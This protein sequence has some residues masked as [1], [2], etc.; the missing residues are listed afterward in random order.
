MRKQ[1]EIN[2]MIQKLSYWITYIN[3]S[4]SKSYTDINK[5]S[6]GFVMNLL[7][8]IYDLNLEDLNKEQAN[9]PGIDLGDA[10]KGMAVQVT[11]EKKS[12]KIKDTY[13]K[14][15]SPKNNIGG[16][17]IG[18]IYNKKVYFF[19]ITDEWKYRFGQS[20]VDELALI[21]QNR[22]CAED[23]ITAGDVIEII[24][25]LFDSN[26]SKFQKVYKLISQYIDTLP[27]IINDQMIVEGFLPCFDRPMFITP[28]YL[29]CNLPD[30]EQ[31]ISDTIEA[32]NTGIYRLRDGTIIKKIIPKTELHDRNLLKE[33]DLIIKDLIL[34]RS[35]YKALIN[36]GEIKKC[37]CDNPN[38]DVHLFSQEACKVM[39]SDRRNILKRVK[40]LSPT[41]SGEFIDI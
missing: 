1:Q 27:D 3:I 4:N 11:S 20:T 36:K 25:D 29:E 18:D 9:Y 2:Y 41:Y 32:I 33:V 37:N 39:D 23:I 21:S 38:C 34:L 8:I 5:L 14:I 30:F 26:N 35:H 24:K 40:Q 10:S 15:Y 17:L 19:V 12:A 22:F 31:A 13:E 16:R 7:N 28:F 6:E